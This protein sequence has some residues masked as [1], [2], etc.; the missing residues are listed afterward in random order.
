MTFLLI[1]HNV[2]MIVMSAAAWL[3]HAVVNQNAGFM[4]ITLKNLIYHRKIV[5]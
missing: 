2:L 3:H 4:Q 5:V 1:D